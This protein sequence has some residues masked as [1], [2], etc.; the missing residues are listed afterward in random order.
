MNGG[1]EFISVNPDVNRTVITLG[2]KSLLE[3][4]QCGSCTAVCPLSE[5][6]D[7]SFRRAIRYTQLGVEEKI[8]GDISPWSCNLH[9]DC[10]D[11][12]PRGA[13]PSEILAAIRR[14][15]SIKYDWTGIAKWWNNS[16]LMA[17]LFVYS[18]LLALSLL[19]FFGYYWQ[20]ILSY[21]STGKL[22]VFS[23][24]LIPVAVAFF[25]SLVF[26]ASNG[27]RAYKFMSKDKKAKIGFIK[28]LRVIASF[29]MKLETEA[30]G[31]PHKRERILEHALILIGIGLFI[32]LG[33]LYLIYPKFF[34]Y[35]VISRALIYSASL[36]LLIGVGS[37]LIK[38]LGSSEKTHW[39]YKRFTHSVDWMSLLTLFPIAVMALLLF[40]FYDLSM[41]LYAYI[42]F[43]LLLSF[44]IPFLLLE[45]AFGKH[46]HWLYKVIAYYIG[47]RAGYFR[48]E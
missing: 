4:Y 13:S 45:F 9:G 46:T 43:A 36:T 32:L 35:E 6:L 16:S 29:F 34:D 28:S 5:A 44:L 14:Y 21:A 31:V 47:A 30:M 3:C 23:E 42:A 27:Y 37:P 12:C 1:S 22:V 17:K 8:L 26:L 10:T 48:G 33:A 40:I 25:V 11:S 2:G 41:I 15:Q 19:I 24:L 7:V 38:R 20:K 18:A 39:Y